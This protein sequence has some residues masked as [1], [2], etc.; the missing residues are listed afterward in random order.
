M[1]YRHGDMEEWQLEAALR[2]CIWMYR[3]GSSDVCY[4]P[5]ID[6]DKKGGQTKKFVKFQLLAEVWCFVDV[7][8]EEKPF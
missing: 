1:L 3:K 5:F 6:V 8:R 7:V 2:H 4:V